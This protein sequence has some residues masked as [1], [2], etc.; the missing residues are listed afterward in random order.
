MSIYD[1]HVDNAHEMLRR[2]EEK[3]MAEELEKRKLGDDN[4]GEKNQG[5]NNPILKLKKDFN[6]EFTDITLDDFT[7]ENYEPMKPQLIFELGI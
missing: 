1:R 4:Q 3:L 5:D 7:L 2:A 6:C